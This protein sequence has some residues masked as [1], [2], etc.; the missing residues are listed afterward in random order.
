MTRFE[1]RVRGLDPGLLT[2]RSL[3][4][5]Q[6]N[7]GDLCNL[8]CTHCH[9]G[10]SPE[11]TR[12]MEPPVT[13]KIAA[14]L[15]ERPHLTLDITG[16]CPEMNPEFRFLVEATEAPGRRRIVRSNLTV[17]TEPGMEW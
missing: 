6:V 14:F 15:A 12:T 5:L 1:E 9:V 16:G 3:Q 13:R 11:G 17:M 7:L 10:A 8:R 4:T 2:L